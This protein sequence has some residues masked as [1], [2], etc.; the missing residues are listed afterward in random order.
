MMV[1]PDR[2]PLSVT[3]IRSIW[4]SLRDF[5]PDVVHVWLPAS[6]SIPMMICARLLGK[7][8]IFSYRSKMRFLR[9][10]GYPE[11]LVVLLCAT[12][13][14]S[15]NP[16][17][18]SNAAF[19]WL[20]RVKQGVVIENGVRVPENVTRVHPS[21]PAAGD[22][23]FIFVGRLTPLKNVS[24]L[25][26]AFGRLERRDWT[27][28]I[29]GD[30][31]LRAD[32][33]RLIKARGLSGRVLLRG[34][35][36]D[37]CRRMAKADVL[38]LPSLSEGMPNALVE[39]FAIGV[40]SIAADIPGHRAIVGGETAVVWVDPS[41]IAAI[42]RALVDVMGGVYELDAIAAKARLI[43]ARFDPVMM[44]AAYCRT[45]RQLGAR[46]AD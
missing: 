15:N 23:R 8:V 43:A 39:A 10:L 9:P 46:E 18:G 34:H 29:C 28:E 25:I 14:V 12:R 19:R 41:S 33:E 22:W 38:I 42:A 31:E 4:R 17:E 3:Y 11:Y 5:N 44:A 7:P 1:S 20:Y 37:V 6:V 30:G 40:P 13:I 2:R 16:V 27:L 32:I 21:Y 35:Q 24:A 45:Y 36:S 26:E